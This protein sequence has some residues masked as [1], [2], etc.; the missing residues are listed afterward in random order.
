MVRPQAPASATGVVSR[1]YESFCPR[2]CSEQ[3]QYRQ[4]LGH[5]AALLLD[6]VE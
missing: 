4:G 1:R 2:Q 6:N 3:P 5:F